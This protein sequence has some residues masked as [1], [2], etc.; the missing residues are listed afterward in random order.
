[1][2]GIGNREQRLRRVL[3]VERKLQKTISKWKTGGWQT[4]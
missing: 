1:M 3:Q 4:E 2:Q